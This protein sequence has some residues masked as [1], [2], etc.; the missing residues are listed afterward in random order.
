MDVDVCAGGDSTRRKMDTMGDGALE[1]VPLE[2]YDSSRA[3]ID[4][5]LRWLFA[6]AYGIDNIPEDLRDP[7]YT[8]QYE[9]EHIKPPVIKLLLS[10][11]LYC[12]V[13]SLILKGDQVAALQGHQSVIQALS[14]KGIYVMDSD[15]T[16]VSESDLNCAPIKMSAH[17]PMIDALMMAYTVEMISIEKVVASVKRFSTFSASKE[18]PFDLEDAMVFW[19]NKVNLKMREITEKE[20]KLKQQLLE[21]PSHQKSPSKWYWKLVPVR[22]RRD[23]LSSRQLPYFP[24]L[25]DL[26]KDVCDGAALLA[27][28]HYYCPELMKLDDICLKEVTSIADSLYNIQLLKEFAN[29]YLNK[30]FYLTTEDMLY[31]PLGLKHNVM[32]FI[33]E[34]FWWFEIVKPDFV[35]PRDFQEIKD[36]RAMQQSKST[37]PPVPISNATKRSFM[38]SPAGMASPAETPLLPPIQSSPEVSSRYYLHPEESELLKG[39]PSYSLSHPL[40]PL[41]QKQQ[42]SLQGEDSPGL[43]HRSNSLTRDDGQP[44]GSVVAWPE[45]KQRPA[46]QPT[47]Y[48][49][50][51]ATDSD[52]DIASGDNVS[53]ARSISKDSLASN[54]INLTPK[55]QPQTGLRKVNGQGLLRNVSIEDEEEEELIAII[56]SEERIN[57]R[58]PYQ[59]DL[60]LQSISSRATTARSPRVQDESSSQPSSFFL[61]PLMPAALK[62]AK[63][64]SVN[65]NK[66]Q[67]SGEGRHKGAASKRLVDGNLPSTRTKVMNSA[68]PD[69]NRTFTPISSSDFT[70]VTDSTLTES[71]Q[72]PMESAFG[73]FRPLATSSVDPAPGEQSGGFFLHC[74][75]S[76]EKATES[77][78]SGSPLCM[79]ESTWEVRQ[80]SDSE[81][82]D[83]DEVDQ[84]LEVA[85][86][87]QPVR[88]KYFGEEESAKLQE[89]MKVKEHEDKDGGSGRSSP[90]LS[91]ISQASSVS[92]AS[93]SIKMTSFA[94]RKLQRINSHE[95]KSS[96][97]SSQ[98]TT[99]DGS[100]CGPVPLTTWRQKRDQSPTRQSKDNVHV[101]AS[102]LVQ[103]HMQLEEKRRAIETQKKKMEALSARQ[104]LKLG[105]AAFLHVVKKGKTESIPQPLKPDYLS[106]E[107]PKV[108]GESFILSAQQSRAEEVSSNN[109]LHHP[110]EVPKEKDMQESRSTVKW[111]RESPTPPT[112]LDTDNKLNSTI[113]LDDSGSEIDVNECNRSIDMLNN[114]ISTIQQQMMQLSL[115]QDLL[116]KQNVQ[117]P[118]TTSPNGKSNPP[119]QKIRPAV[120]FVEPLS[121]TGNGT[122][123]KPPRFGL[124]RSPRSKPTDLKLSK[125]KQQSAPRIIT[126]TQSIETLPHLRP[127]P[128]NRTAKAEPEDASPISGIPVESRSGTL[129]KGSPRSSSSFRLHEEANQRTFV[130]STS[131]DTNNVSE[132]EYNECQANHLKE[133]ELNSSDGSGKENIPF[134]ESSKSKTQL[135]E[136][137]LSDLKAPTE[138]GS[139]EIQ[140]TSADTLGEGDQK[141]VLGFFFKDEQKAED[142]LAKKRA[143]FLLKQQRKA[144]E[145]RLRKHLLE[146]EIEQKREEARRKAEEDRIRKEEEKARRELIKQEYL[147]RKQQEIIEEQGQG[148]LKTKPKKQRPK[149]VHREETYSDTPSKCSSTRIPRRKQI[150]TAC[151][152]PGDIWGADNLSSA[153]SGSSLS[154]ASAATTEAESVHSGGAASQRGESVESFPGLSRNAS[155]NTERDWENASTA[156]SVASVAEYTGPKLF[157]EPSAKSNKT[158]IH[159]AISHCCLA[160]KVNEPHKNSILEVIEKCESNHLM[161][162]FRDAGCMFRSL[163]SY[164][165]DTEEIHKVTG[166]GPKS[167][168]KKMIDKLYKYSSDRKQFNVIPAKTVSVSVDALTIHNHLWQVKRP[169]VPKKSGK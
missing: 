16:P 124:G 123:R 13:C 98:K 130:L 120:H 10:S 43:R 140:D 21:S 163:Y 87:I 118:T 41:R 42:K 99:P 168:S 104:R 81:V 74:S 15:D 137:D 112:V 52:I 122:V 88:R 57:N 134:E 50:H 110:Q 151:R 53:L 73:P 90:C 23:Q 4:A 32:V 92:M 144:E 101:L 35:Q 160:G 80:D 63:E 6:K 166:T 114:A 12:R 47:P 132:Q 148:K 64:K 49:L 79:P 37:R 29:E 115:Q 155:R 56:R 150:P 84:D 45:K 133:A 36:A 66:E 75:E 20:L 161:I 39:S 152:S 11:E 146:A 38:V 61:E 82:L 106:K 95:A 138:E 103:L 159:N 67:E 116:M 143:A 69:L 91:T 19:I 131:K 167:I 105:K 139:F 111:A 58:L 135:I 149:S 96:T 107:D 68:D 108:N 76:E 2:L 126:P 157:K 30:G 86:E 62:P 164:F 14:R 154:L 46:S 89:D 17:M 48:A 33:A 145:A 156:S 26:V 78:G 141:S 109:S 127:F 158:I 24:L 136:V 28:I 165:P 55:H 83:M 117:S 113:L 97:S 59:G 129:E 40:L 8:D 27:V 100:E 121:P 94:E 65:V 169:S 54:V 44:R 34:L 85:N 162:L 60:E 18:L 71:V 51:Y 142:E 31:A 7:F 3:K 72:L 125:E 5:N 153:Q 102:E 77:I 1:V 93:G 22:Y 70:N 128:G 147:R 119:E 25:E 9:Q